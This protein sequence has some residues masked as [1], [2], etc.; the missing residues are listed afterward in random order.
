MPQSR[1]TLQRPQ[2]PKAP[3][4]RFRWSN[5]SHRAALASLYGNASAAHFF[6]PQQQ[7]LAPPPIVRLPVYTDLCLFDG[8]Q[9]H[10]GHSTTRSVRPPPYHAKSRCRNH[11]CSGFNRFTENRARFQRFV[12]IEA[13]NL[14]LHHFGNGLGMLLGGRRRRCASTITRT[15]GSVPEGRRSTRPSSPSACFG[16]RHGVGDGLRCRR[17]RACPSRAR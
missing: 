15:T 6:C 16:G 9:L 10:T 1:R 13:L 12:E 3:P 11:T 4:S 8:G 17:R 5:R 2:I 14:A 7:V